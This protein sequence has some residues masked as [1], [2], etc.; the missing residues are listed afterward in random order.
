MWFEMGECDP[1]R[2]RMRISAETLRRLDEQLFLDQI[3]RIEECL[4]RD[5]NWSLEAALQVA[6]A[7]SPA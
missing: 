6:E 3:A 2:R 5:A 1:W 7:C 4:E